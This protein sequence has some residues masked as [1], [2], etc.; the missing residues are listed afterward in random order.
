MER[1]KADAQEIVNIQNGS[2][3]ESQSEYECIVRIRDN[4]ASEV[5]QNVPSQCKTERIMNWLEN[6]NNRL[7]VVKGDELS[8][9]SISD[10]PE[11]SPVNHDRD[12]FADIKYN[13]NI[14]SQCT[15]HTCSSNSTLHIQNKHEK[16]SVDY[17]EVRIAPIMCVIF[18]FWKMF[19]FS[20]EKF[21]CRKKICTLYSVAHLPCFTKTGF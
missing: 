5:P 13:D 14:H 7:G 10:E 21:S 4:S 19:R 18:L 17:N 1:N 3:E 16:N 8:V 20:F 11:E 9:I 6:M 12:Q 2:T 15:K